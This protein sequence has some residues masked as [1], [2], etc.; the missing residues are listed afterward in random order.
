MLHYSTCSA[1][2]HSRLST[3]IHATFHDLP[4][5]D[6]IPNPNPHSDAN[7]NPNPNSDANPNT[8][9][10]F[11][12]AVKDPHRMMVDRLTPD[13]LHTTNETLGIFGQE[14]V[15]A[16]VMFKRNGMAEVLGRRGFPEKEGRK[17][18]Y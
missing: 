9:P 2:L 6:I 1:L 3:L 11:T 7:P 13:F 17:E 14:D 5:F 4:N 10:T 8:N 16:P 18:A 15:E 12:Q